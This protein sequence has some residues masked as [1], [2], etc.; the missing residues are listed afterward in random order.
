LKIFDFS[1]TATASYVI[2]VRR[3][4][5]GLP[6][7]SHPATTTVAGTAPAKALRAMLG[8]LIKKADLK[9]PAFKVNKIKIS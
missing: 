5:R 1:P 3:A 7:P 4:G 2:S 8:A 9:R 6:P